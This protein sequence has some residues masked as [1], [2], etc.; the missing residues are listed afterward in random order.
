MGTAG[1]G[2][3]FQDFVTSGVG[4]FLCNFAV[5]FLD[6]SVLGEE[7]RTQEQ[8]KQLSRRAWELKM[9]PAASVNQR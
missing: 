3:K 1:Q 4:C 8:Q 2:D 5:T 9:S 6:I 7:G